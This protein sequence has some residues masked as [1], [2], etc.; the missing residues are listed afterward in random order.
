MDLAGNRLTGRLPQFWASSSSFEYFSAQN[1]LLTGSIPT[2]AITFR[3][4]GGL[5]EINLRNNLLT[6][7]LPVAMALLPI[8]RLDLGFNQFSGKFDALLG[9]LNFLIS[10]AAEG[11]MLSGSLPPTMASLGLKFFNLDNNRLTGTIP[12]S[13]SNQGLMRTLRLSNNTGLS[14]VIPESLGNWTSLEWLGVDDTSLKAISQNGNAQML[15]PFL[16]LTGDF[17]TVPAVADMACPLPAANASIFPQ[18]TQILLDPSY[19]GY[20]ECICYTGH[21]VTADN[22]SVSC[23]PNLV[24]SNRSIAISL[25]VVVP[26][27]VALGILLDALGRLRRGS[28]EKYVM[29]WV[30]RKGAPGTGVDITLVSTDVEGS[31]ELWEWDREIMD[32]AIDVHD[33]VIR[34]QLGRFDGYEVTTE[35]DA[36]LM[37]FHDASDAVAWCIA[38]QQALLVAKWPVQ[39]Q[40]H[41]KSCIR[42]GAQ[43]HPSGPPA[44]GPRKS[45]D[46]EHATPST[47]AEGWEAR[48]VGGGGDASLDVDQLAGALKPHPSQQAQPN[49]LELQDVTPS[50]VAFWGLAVRMGVATG[51]VTHTTTHPLT[52]RTVYHGPLVQLVGAVVGVAHGGQIV[53]ESSTFMAMSPALG[54]I[55]QRVPA[56]PDYDALVSRPRGH[57]R[58][59]RG[60]SHLPKLAGKGSGAAPGDLAPQLSGMSITSPRGE[61]AGVTMPKRLP[62]CSAS[63]A[64]LSAGSTPTAGPAS[65]DSHSLMVMDMGQHVVHDYDQPLTL[66]QIMVPGLEDR[67]RSFPPLATARQLSPGYFDAPGTREAPLGGPASQG[68]KTELPLVSLVFSAVDGL[69]A[70]RAQG[71]VAA[72]HAMTLYKDV[73]RRLLRLTEGYECQEAEG[74]FMLAFHKP[75][76]AVQFCLLV[77]EEMLKV[78]WREDVL[79]L[80]QCQAQVGGRN[81][82]LIFQGPRIKMGIYEGTPTRVAPHTTTGSTDYF[83]PLVNRAARF[84]NGAAHGGQVVGPSAIIPGLLQAWGCEKLPDGQSLGPEAQMSGPTPSGKS[85]PAD[86]DLTTK[87][88]QDLLKASYPNPDP[89]FSFGVGPQPSR[90]GRHLSP[91]ASTAPR[92]ISLSAVRSVHPISGDPADPQKL[93]ASWVTHQQFGDATDRG[94]AT[95]GGPAFWAHAT[96]PQPHPLPTPSGPLYMHRKASTVGRRSRRFTRLWSAKQPRSSALMSELGPAGSDSSLTA[97]MM[98]AETEEAADANPENAVTPFARASLDL[99]S[100]S[101]RPSR[102][103]LSE[104]GEVMEISRTRH[105]GSALQSLHLTAERSAVS[106]SSLAS[107]ARGNDRLLEALSE[108]E[109]GQGL[110]YVVVMKEEPFLPP[111]KTQSVINE[112]HK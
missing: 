51:R 71:E 42:H 37:A 15:P 63:A 41:P 40:Y 104:S 45:Q 101:M 83:G 75:I 112:L 108:V 82:G 96:Q 92:E 26:V 55:A 30:K 16:Y 103:G 78:H 90:A 62:V 61:S 36:F 43:L 109:K 1:N 48:A 73:I 66:H 57:S 47:K 44:G 70:M 53:T 12:A 32:K 79:A 46:V 88:Q 100:I 54:D 19:F 84:C 86:P 22:G 2:S 56:Q 69:K 81:Q 27:L 5:V 68:L 20:Q 13:W 28:Y 11:N 111:S 59:W 3:L 25:L 67:A 98:V 77:Q 95:A 91:D 74:N 23:E 106:I 39:L 10:F 24:H 87:A 64:L 14:G 72:E 7:S 76:K 94:T 33:H 89:S 58:I 31:T 80:P 49:F 4:Y 93:A 105:S 85:A 29:R 18:A 97:L 17:A 9:A 65:Q 102:S 8:V 110:Q 21:L 6:G 60:P 35:G 107:S 50:S 38:T 34:T 99:R 52:R